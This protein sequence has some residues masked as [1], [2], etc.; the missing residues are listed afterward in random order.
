M[1]QEQEAVVIAERATGNPVPAILHKELEELEI[2]DAE[3]VWS[4]ER[5]LHRPGSLHTPGSAA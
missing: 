4:P 2:I 5:L 3:I 1:S